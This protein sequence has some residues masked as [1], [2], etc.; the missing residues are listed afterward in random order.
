[1]PPPSRIALF[2]NLDMVILPPRRGD[3]YTSVATPKTQDVKGDVLAT[4]EDPSSTCREETKSAIGSRSRP[5]PG[6]DSSI[7]QLSDD[8]FGLD[9][10]ADPDVARSYL[11]SDVSQSSESL[12]GPLY[13]EDIVRPASVCHS[14]DLPSDDGS[15]FIG[16]TR[17]W[18]DLGRTVLESA[19]IRER[20]SCSESGGQTSKQER[21]FTALDPHEGSKTKRKRVSDSVAAIIQTLINSGA[22]SPASQ[23]NES[24]F[25][26]RKL[27]ADIP[28]SPSTS[29]FERENM[30][31]V[32]PC[33]AN[34][35]TYLQRH[36]SFERLPLGLR[37]VTPDAT[38]EK[39]LTLSGLRISQSTVDS[40]LEILLKDLEH[41][42][43]AQDA[44]ADLAYYPQSTEARDI[45]RSRSYDSF[46]AFDET[47]NSVLKSQL[48]K[49]ERSRRQ[50]HS[51][52]RDQQLSTEKARMVRQIRLYPSHLASI[53][54]PT[55][56][57]SWL[58]RVPRERTE[59]HLWLI[60]VPSPWPD[61]AT[62]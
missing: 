8:E 2:D 29:Q 52:N 23:R 18:I 50:A 5:G 49:L 58:T 61:A 55:L 26:E 27:H 41:R 15:V 6:E 4:R 19:R 24:E 59:I 54:R 1:M 44:E 36:E 45:R 9:F 14:W 13:I 60:S 40:K 11:G 43:G 7:A 12:G 10:E 17:T 20:E 39:Q 28:R 47:I 38:I 53:F 42:F 35:E 46:T 21:P 56:K 31:R 22:R 30:R 48:K 32:P 16:P 51:V 33:P 25:K 3:F 62:S 57:P 34:I 37:T